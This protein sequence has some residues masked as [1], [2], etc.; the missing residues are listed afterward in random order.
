MK[1][2]AI[3]DMFL[4]EEAFRKVLVESNLFDEYKGFNWKKG[5]DRVETRALIR[6]IETEGSEAYSLPEEVKDEILDA[7]VVFIHMCP[8]GKEIIKK[9]KK[10]KYIV[11]ARGGVENIAVREAQE[12]GIRVIHCPI[13]NAHAVAELTVGLMICETRN[14]TRA[15]YALKNGTWREKYPNSGNI[16]E[17]RSCTIGLIGFGAIGQLVVD[18]LKPFECK[19]LVN[20]PYIDSEIIQAKGCIP[21]SKEELLK[22]SDIVSLHG[23]IGPND[24]PIIGK[25]ELDLMKPTSYLINTARAVLVDMN[26]VENALLNHQIMGAALDVF[27]KE[28]LEKDDIICQIDNCTITNHRGGDTKDSY[29]RSPEILLEQLKEVLATGK[30]KYML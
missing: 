7:D 4:D 8:I 14:V 22:E 15:N 24:P 3:G 16:R 19:I 25:Q 30:T 26:A 18:L 23:R 6:K 27:P 28:P 1:C 12:K 5:L 17:I 11:S 29:D 13:H 21:V 2:V 9:A 10:L 20:D